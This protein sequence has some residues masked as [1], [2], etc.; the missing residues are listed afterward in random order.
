M[1]PLRSS[2]GPAVCT[3]GTSSSAAMICA[4]DV[5]PRPGGPASST[6]SSASPRAAPPRSRP[7]AA[8]AAP[9]WPTNSSSVR[10]RSERSSSSSP[11]SAPG[12]WMRSRLIAWP[13]AARWPAGPRPSR[14]RR[15]RAAPAASAGWKP[16]S[17][18]PSRASVAR[19]VAAGDGDRLAEVVLGTPTFSRSSTTIRSAV[20]LPMPGT[21]CRR[22]TSPAASAATSSRGEPPLSTARATFGPT[23]C[24]PMSSQEEVALLLGG[25]AVEGQRV[26]AHDQVGVQRHGAARRRGPGAASRPR[27]PGGSRPRPRSR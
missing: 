15:R 23:D 11:S 27:R 1:S 25:E 16:S 7:A 4:S 14:P 13:P 22:A 21:A 20:R 18:R 10:G 19:V 3:K 9:S 17:S 8:R 26:V 5:L 6:W 12:V 2:A 24:T